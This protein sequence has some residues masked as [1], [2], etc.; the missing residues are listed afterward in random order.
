MKLSVSCLG[1]FIGRS[2]SPI[3]T[4]EKIM[5]VDEAERLKI[6]YQA[7]SRKT[8]ADPIDKKP[9]RILLKNSL[10]NKE[11]VLKRRVVPTSQR[12]IPKIPII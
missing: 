4:I 9:N 11:I 2:K 6:E 7:T 3:E 12:I 5:N 8:K 1:S 10:P